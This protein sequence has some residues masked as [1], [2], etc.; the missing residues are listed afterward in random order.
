MSKYI[1]KKDLKKDSHYLCEARNFHVGR[2]D[3]KKFLYIE[4][5]YTGYNINNELHWDDDPKYG[6][7]KPLKEITSIYHLTDEERK[8]I[9]K[10]L[11]K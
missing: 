10:R 1:A 8:E 9:I 6:T 2:W 5:D 4:H 11:K 3:G 7:V